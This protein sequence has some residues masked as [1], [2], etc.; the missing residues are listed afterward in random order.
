MHFG[1]HKAGQES[2]VFYNSARREKDTESSLFSVH[3]PIL[4]D[5]RLAL[6]EFEVLAGGRSLLKDHA[7]DFA[8]LLIDEDEFCAEGAPLAGEMV[9]VVDTAE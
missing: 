6:D 1:R 9:D 3:L 2:M 8:A 5:I 7:D 4:E